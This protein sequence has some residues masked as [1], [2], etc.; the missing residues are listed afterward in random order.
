MPKVISPS[1]TSLSE[2]SCLFPQVPCTNICKTP[3]EAHVYLQLGPGPLR[4][5]WAEH[6][7]VPLGRNSQLHAS[8]L[9]CQGISRTIFLSRGMKAQQSVPLQV[10]ER[11]VSSFWAMLTWAKQPGLPEL[12]RE[13]LLP[14]LSLSLTHTHTHTH[15]HTLFLSRFTSVPGTH[16]RT[17][18][19]PFWA[20]TPLFILQ[21][22]W[23][24]SYPPGHE[25]TILESLERVKFPVS[26]G[27]PLSPLVN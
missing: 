22:I 26:P 23:P 24:A 2:R 11:S 4:N 25:T 5:P 20:E 18:R 16:K 1:P 10:R 19:P 15:T 13:I 14:V 12:H 8:M 27:A 21:F 9:V 6:S 7:K 17:W 3:W